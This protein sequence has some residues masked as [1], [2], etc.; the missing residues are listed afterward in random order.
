MATNQE[1]LKN[2][3]AELRTIAK[4]QGPK[5]AIARANE[6]IRLEGQPT[7][8]S[9]AADGT[10]YPTESA[11]GPGGQSIRFGPGAGP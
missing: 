10:Y 5:Q 3:E 11:I 4:T 8:G 6:L 2:Y 1:V 7:A 9:V